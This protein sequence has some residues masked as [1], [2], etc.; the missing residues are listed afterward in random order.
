MIGRPL[1]RT[2]VIMHTARWPT[3]C[4][5]PESE[6]GRVE[7]GKV[8]GQFDGQLAKNL[9]EKMVVNAELGYPQP[10]RHHVASI[11]SL[12]QHC[13]VMMG[14]RGWETEQRP[15]AY[16]H[17]LPHPRITS[18]I[19]NHPPPILLPSPLVDNLRQPCVPYARSCLPLRFD[20]TMCTRPLPRLC[21]LLPHVAP[22]DPRHRGNRHVVPALYYR[23]NPTRIYTPSNLRTAKIWHLR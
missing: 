12:R 9:Q 14:G 5:L 2:W 10:H 3:K 18:S 13:K 1:A 23:R 21:P 4:W 19:T 20:D 17:H 16:R 11:H 7:V 8:L 6:V 15:R 22:T